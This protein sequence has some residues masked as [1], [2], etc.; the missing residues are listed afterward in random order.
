M[1]KGCRQSDTHFSIVYETMITAGFE[2]D[3]SYEF[4]NKIANF[5]DD[6]FQLVYSEPKK[7]DKNIVS[8]GNL[9]NEC[10]VFEFCAID[11]SMVVDIT[12][13][14][15]DHQ[16]GSS[17]EIDIEFY[18]LICGLKTRMTFDQALDAS[19]EDIKKRIIY[20]IDMIN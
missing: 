8:Y 2:S 17:P 20:N 12:F 5:F 6:L 14:K 18:R 15:Y 9:F 7:I 13:K 1:T 4:S 16:E 10:A 11:S 3:V 19:S